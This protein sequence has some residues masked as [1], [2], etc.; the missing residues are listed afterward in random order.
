[1]YLV[2]I[3]SGDPT[4]R[5]NMRIELRAGRPATRLL[6]LKECSTVTRRSVN[7][8]DKEKQATV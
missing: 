7:D 5:A 1:V 4:S 2:V 8:L 3:Y 6:K